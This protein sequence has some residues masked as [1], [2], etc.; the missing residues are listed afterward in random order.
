MG[1]IKKPRHGPEWYIQRDLMTF[2]R[3]RG[4]MIERMIGNALQKGIP[5]LYCRHPKWGER[6]IDVKNPV[7]Y[8]FTREQK[9]KWPVWEHF[10][11]GIWI[12]T[13][14][15]QTEYDKLFD[16]PNWREFWK[17]TYGEVPDIESLL[18]ELDKIEDDDASFT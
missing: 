13:A 11:C 3:Q 16:H 15:T 17:T 2:M 18:A 9:L 4:W 8:S 1:R 6:W 7:K 10:R 14:A 5:D 12:L